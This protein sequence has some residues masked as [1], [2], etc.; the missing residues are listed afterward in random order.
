LVGRHDKITP[1]EFSQE[2]ANGI[3]QARL[4]IFEHSGHNPFNDEPEKFRKIVSDFLKAEN[5]QVVK[6]G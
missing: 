4:E 6:S 3:P 2:I 1:V 5:L